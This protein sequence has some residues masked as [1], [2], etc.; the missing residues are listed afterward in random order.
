MIVISVI[1]WATGDQHCQLWVNDKKF[2][3][4]R[5]MEQ[6]TAASLGVT[7]FYVENAMIHSI[8]MENALIQIQTSPKKQAETGHLGLG[9]VF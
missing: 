7:P 8:S 4:G 2:T 5:T 9:I 1:G 6:F 3:S